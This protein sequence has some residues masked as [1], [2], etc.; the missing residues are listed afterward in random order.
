MIVRES[1]ESYIMIT[2]HDHAKISGDIAQQWDKKYLKSERHQFEL[3]Q[4]IY[5]HDLGWIPVDSAPMWND[6]KQKPYS[7]IDFPA[8][9]KMVHYE[10][11][12]NQVEKNNPYG[13]LL[14]SKHYTYLVNDSPEEEAFREHEVNRQNKIMDQLDIS[15]PELSY[16]FQI[17]Q[18]CDSLSL[19]I[20]M[21]GP[22]AEK[23]FS[24]FHNGFPVNEDFL[25]AEGKDVVGYWENPFTFKVDPHPFSQ[26][27]ETSLRYKEV[28]KNEI[29]DHGII[30]AY[31]KTEFS[32]FDF[33]I[34]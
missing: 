3:V 33:V 27:I 1:D 31:L 22:E 16:P 4:G 17:L 29:Q 11:G 21:H 19:F 34:C 20:C 18:L 26:K 9:P 30:R 28:F 8:P 12:I 10:H 32:D 13:A 24:N 23:E 6:N 7:F 2:Q 25:F 15:E 14:Q 5:E